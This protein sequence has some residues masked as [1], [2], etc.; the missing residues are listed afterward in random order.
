MVPIT[1]KGVRQGEQVV[2]T[3]DETADGVGKTVGVFEEQ[4]HDK[5]IRRP[6]DH[7]DGKRKTDFECLGVIQ[8]Q[9]LSGLSLPF[10]AACCGSNVIRRSHRGGILRGHLDGVAHAVDVVVH[11]F[12]L[13]QTGRAK[14]RVKV[15]TLYPIRISRVKS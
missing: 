10:S 4:R 6:E 9:R 3:H 1:M 11:K 8:T 2:K 15:T 14:V 7:D 5:V 12:L 13:T